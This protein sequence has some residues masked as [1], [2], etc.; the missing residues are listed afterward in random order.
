ML[1]FVGLIVVAL[2]VGEANGDRAATGYLV[3]TAVIL[4]VGWWR[5]GAPARKRLA[6][7]REQRERELRDREQRQELQCRRDVESADFLAWRSAYTCPA[8]P[9]SAEPA[10]PAV[11][12]AGERADWA[13]PTRRVALHR[14]EFLHLPDHD[15]ALRLFGTTVTALVRSLGLEA[16]AY[17]TEIDS[18]VDGG[19]EPGILRRRGGELGWLPRQP[20]ARLTAEA[21]R[22][23]AR[24]A[25]WAVARQGH[26]RTL[27]PD[28]VRELSKIDSLIA[29]ARREVKAWSRDATWD[30]PGNAV[31]PEGAWPRILSGLHR[32]LAES[33]VVLAGLPETPPP[34]PRHP[35]KDA[36]FEEHVAPSAVDERLMAFTLEKAERLTRLCDPSARVRPSDWTMGAGVLDGFLTDEVGDRFSRVIEGSAEISRWPDGAVSHE[37]RRR[38]CLSYMALVLNY[39]TE[40]S[41]N[42][43]EYTDRSGMG[44]KPKVVNNFHA[45]A[46]VMIA[47]K[48][49]NI[50]STISAVSLRGD[51]ALA[52]KIQ[53]LSR[54]IQEEPALSDEQ[55]ADL[56]D[57]VDEMADAAKDPESPRSAK[58]G[59]RA[60]EAVR[61]A[62]ALIGATSP[63]AV[64]LA[65]WE[66]VF[67]N[68]H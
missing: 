54:A 53:A 13:I 42:M 20:G 2:V 1:W 22:L 46:S 8:F 48:I 45:A 63:V 10:E 55:R 26:L 27:R 19:C 61:T 14:G 12:P 51:D 44:D 64:A 58:R 41:Q 60:L 3:M 7:S 16:A 35:P 65:D 40:V 6:A 5:Q 9:E 38:L 23:V 25:S 39:L 62:G 52:T 32:R 66:H 21:A 29:D 67:A 49:Q 68:I 59:R 28:A 24:I 18:L 15:Q 47:E 17:A 11:V 37:V 43:P 31:M 50:N 4:L 30:G 56:L 57:D 36:R 34:Q 33:S